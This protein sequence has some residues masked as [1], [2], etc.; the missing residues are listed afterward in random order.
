MVGLLPVLIDRWYLTLDKGGSSLYTAV[1]VGAARVAIAAGA[2]GAGAHG[3]CCRTWPLL[4]LPPLLL[5]PLPL[6][7]ALP[8]LATSA[9]SP[10]L[11]HHHPC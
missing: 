10:R 8:A 6:R 3:A 9:T 5:P 4:C 1:T 2:V 7:N 11:A